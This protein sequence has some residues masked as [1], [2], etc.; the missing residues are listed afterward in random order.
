M[1][2]SIVSAAA[3]VLGVA[4]SS[5]GP[6][7]PA[8]AQSFSPAPGTY[9]LSGP[10]TFADTTVYTCTATISFTVDAAGAATVTGRTFSG[11]G[12]CGTA[13]VPYGAWTIAPGPGSGISLAMGVTAGTRSCYG[14]AQ[15]PLL[16]SPTRVTLPQTDLPAVTPGFGYCRVVGAVLYATPSSLTVVP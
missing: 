13:V 10:I 4:L 8:A 14:L 16:A 11:S 2:R 6:A 9:I 1:P 3:L 12:W 15:G 7:A 5:A